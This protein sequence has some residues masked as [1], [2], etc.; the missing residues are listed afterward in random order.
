MLTLGAG[1]E[2]WFLWCLSLMYTEASAEGESPLTAVST[3]MEMD[4][5][6]GCHV[7]SHPH[8]QCRGS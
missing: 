2:A 4:W 6:G 5:R 3:V 7:L 1:K 8:L